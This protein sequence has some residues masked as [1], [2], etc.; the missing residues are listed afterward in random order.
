MSGGQD[1]P[2]AD[3]HAGAVFVGD[4]IGIGRLWR[5]QGHEP[6]AER[7]G[8]RLR[9]G[10]VSPGRSRR[11]R[12][13]ATTDFSFRAMTSTSVFSIAAAA[14]KPE[15]GSWA[16][17]SG[18]AHAESED[19][20]LCDAVHSPSPRGRGGSTEARPR[21]RSCGAFVI[22]IHHSS[23]SFITHH[24]SFSQSLRRQPAFGVERGHA[25]AAGGGDGLAI[26]VVGHVAGGENALHAGIRPGGRGPLDDTSSRSAPVCLSGMPYWACG[27]WPGRRRSRLS[28]SRARRRCFARRTPVTPSLSLPSTSAS[29]RFQRISI[30]GLAS[31][32]CGHDL[33]RPQLVAAMD[34]IDRAGELGQVVG[35]FDGRIAA[36]D[37]GQRLVAE[38]RQRPVANGARADAAVLELLLGG[39][40]EIVRPGAGGHDHGVRLVGRCRRRRSA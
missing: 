20:E 3:D 19:C 18:N 21:D 31:A 6:A 10:N 23:S 2:A 13:M 11:T 38:S 7:V 8:P 9:V 17:R 5:G 28:P 24:S 33:R 26:V 14:S 39:Q 4:E 1:Q 37:D 16:E 27:R 32:R 12:A 15:G 29:V 34:Q 36:A 22:V 40:A 35:L 25:A 30:F